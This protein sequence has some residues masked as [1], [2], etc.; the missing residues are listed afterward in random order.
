MMKATKKDDPKPTTTGPCLICGSGSCAIYR[1]AALTEEKHVD[2][3]ALLAAHKV[4]PAEVVHD[5]E[6]NPVVGEDGKYPGAVPLEPMTTKPSKSFHRNG[7][8]IGPLMAKV[9][10]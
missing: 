3:G 9:R 10:R 5:E 6:G 4:K 7:G 1:F 2:H 8:R